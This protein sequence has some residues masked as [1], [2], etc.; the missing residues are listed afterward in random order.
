MNM[1]FIVRVLIALG[2]IALGISWITSP[3]TMGPGIGVVIVG[4]GL[5]VSSVYLYRHQNHPTK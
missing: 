5:G 4:V 2:F 3:G 1:R